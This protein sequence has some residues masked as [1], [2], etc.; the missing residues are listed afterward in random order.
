MIPV[1]TTRCAPLVDPALPVPGTQGRCVRAGRHR[2]LAEEKPIRTAAAWDS[3]RLR[4]IT[5]SL[6]PLAQWFFS[7]CTTVT[8]PQ[9]I[10]HHESQV[11]SI[12]HPRRIPRTTPAIVHPRCGC[13]GVFL[14]G[15]ESRSGHFFDFS[16]CR[17]ADG[18]R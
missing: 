15:L 8:S 7:F 4:P 9:L 6:R 10:N 2:N 17:Q 5:A 11:Y 16:H 18:V 1:A 3:G 14:E 12:L 13:V